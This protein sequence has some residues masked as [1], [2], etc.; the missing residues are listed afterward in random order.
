MIKDN[1]NWKLGLDVSESAASEILRKLGL[2]MWRSVTKNT[3]VDTGRARANWQYTDERTSQILADN[4]ASKVQAASTVNKMG[5]TEVFITN[6]VEYISILEF[7]NGIAGST[8]Q[9]GDA[10]GRNAIERAQNTLKKIAR[11][12]NV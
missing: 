1:V 6:N 3:R 10:M 12:V 8:L 11:K 9:D 7:G 4:T 5:V 2:D